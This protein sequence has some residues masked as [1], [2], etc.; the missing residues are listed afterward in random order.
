MAAWF[1]SYARSFSAQLPRGSKLDETGK[2]LRQGH[3]F[4]A[5]TNQ[6]LRGVFGVEE[7]LEA[8]THLDARGL[9][10]LGLVLRL[11]PFLGLS[12]HVAGCLG[13][14]ALK[15]LHWS[16]TCP[17]QEPPD[18]PAEGQGAAPLRGSHHW[19][20]AITCRANRLAIP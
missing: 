13:A 8:E 18:R 2:R 7:Q 6:V 5:R 14:A 19:L 3:S 15:A 12:L 4:R 9:R 11:C 20:A 10:L 17:G 16:M 1:Y